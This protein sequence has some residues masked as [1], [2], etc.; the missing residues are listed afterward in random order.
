MDPHI[1]LSTFDWATIGALVVLAW[2][3]LRR[4]FQSRDR[5]AATVDSLALEVGKLRTWMAENYV[6]KVEHL[7]EIDRLEDSIAKHAEHW[8]EEMG[9]HLADAHPRRDDAHPRRDDTH[10]RRSP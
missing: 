9:N 8:R 1:V 2:F 6:T 7:R 5:L 4:D 3:L 10:P